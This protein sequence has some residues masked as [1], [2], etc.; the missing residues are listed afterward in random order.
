LLL[1]CQGYPQFQEHGHEVQV[2]HIVAMIAHWLAAVV[3]KEQP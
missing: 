3:L 2:K 1:L